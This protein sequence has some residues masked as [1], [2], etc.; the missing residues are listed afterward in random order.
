MVLV[1]SHCHLNYPCFEQAEGGIGA[2]LAKAAQANVHYVQTIC[3]KLAEFEHIYAMAEA[4]Q[5]LFCSFGIHP[6]H[7]G[8]ICYRLTT[9]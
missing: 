4:H 2:V 6:H 3:T 8:K 9:L 1:D 7:A 5:N